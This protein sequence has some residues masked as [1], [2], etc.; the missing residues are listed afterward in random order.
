MLFKKFK[1]YTGR[2][3]ARRSL[4]LVASLAHNFELLAAWSSGRFS[5]CWM[6]S[7]WPATTLLIA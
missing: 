1:Q 3:Q 5:T 6:F 7:C 4:L 2:R